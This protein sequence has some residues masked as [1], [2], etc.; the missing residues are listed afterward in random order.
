M[1]KGSGYRTKGHP[2]TRALA[3][4]LSVAASRGLATHGVS[5]YELAD[6][7]IMLLGAPV[8]A[9]LNKRERALAL[10]EWLSTSGIAPL[11]ANGKAREVHRS[12]Q[13]EIEAFY[14][15]WE[16]K[17][18]RYEF[19]KGRE[20]RCLCCGAG[21][22]HG[23]RVVVDHIKPI[24][25]H[26]DLRLDPNNLQVLCDDCNKGKGSCDET[27]WLKQIRPQSLAAFRTKFRS[28]NRTN[29]SA[30]GIAIPSTC[31][32]GRVPRESG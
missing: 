8:S 7:L 26:W 4:I 14:D 15:S 31:R 5:A 28:V 29:F 30:A 32:A 24:R 1:K 25:H 12:R 2:L 20:R 18:V 9:D 6:Q 17:K 22:E 16:W 11:K 10:H 3:R 21:P 19:L 13:A 27:D 23:V